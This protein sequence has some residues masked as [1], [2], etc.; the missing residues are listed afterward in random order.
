[1]NLPKPTDDPKVADQR[2]ADAL[3]SVLTDPA[4]RALVLVAVQMAIK[5]HLLAARRAKSSTGTNCPST[6]AESA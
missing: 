1:M 4:A 3:E 5:A 2:V 6:E